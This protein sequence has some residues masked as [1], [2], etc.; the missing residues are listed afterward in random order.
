MAKFVNALTLGG[1][2]CEALGLDPTVTTSI[3]IN[4]PIN[5]LPTVVV[6]MLVADESSGHF[7]TTLKRYVLADPDKTA[8]A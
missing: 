5:E 4:C 1:Q 3:T 2:L 7:V 8:A 6:G